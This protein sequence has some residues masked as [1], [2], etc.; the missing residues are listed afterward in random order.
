MLFTCTRRKVTGA[1][2]VKMPHLRGS[3]TVTPAPSSQLIRRREHTLRMAS[4]YLLAGAVTKQ[5]VSMRRIIV[6]GLTLLALSCAVAFGQSELQGK[7]FNKVKMLMPM[8]DSFQATDVTVIFESNRLVVRSASGEEL[9]IFPYSGIRSAAYTLSKGPRYQGTP[10]TMAMA[11]V[12]AFP[13]F[14]QKV[15]RHRLE[16]QSDQ[17]SVLLDLNKDNYKALLTAF[18]SNTGRKV[19]ADG[20]LAPAQGVAAIASH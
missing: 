14:V 5:G 19:V 10:A 20:T 12:F 18:Q 15:E 9:K 7:E 1:D 8:G 3:R 2:T 16:V 11:N 4:I 6:S 13:L 17:T